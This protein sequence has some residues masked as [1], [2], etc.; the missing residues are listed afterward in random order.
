MMLKPALEIISSRYTVVGIL[1]DMDATMRLFDS[2]LG[3]GSF[4]W[5]AESKK[6]GALNE[7]HTRKAEEHAVLHEALT[8]PAIVRFI[9][10]D[11]IL[12]EHALRVH[13]KQV[14]QYGL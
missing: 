6:L 1:E 2:A 7:D 4:N 10:L 14:Q 9:W 5:T 12:Y 8:D 11:I 3:M 13:S